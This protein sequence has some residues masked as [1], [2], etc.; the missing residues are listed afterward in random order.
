MDVKEVTIIIVFAV[1]LLIGVIGFSNPG[2]GRDR[3]PGRAIGLW[4]FS[5]AGWATSVLWQNWFGP[6][7]GSRFLSGVSL[8]SGPLWISW[9]L[10][11]KFDIRLL[12]KLLA[13]LVLLY[14]SVFILLDRSPFPITAFAL[15]AGYTSIIITIARIA[16]RNH[17]KPARASRRLLFV[18]AVPFG[19]A[20]ML[21]VIAYF[22]PVLS[23]GYLYGGALVASQAA[24]IVA[25]REGWLPQEK[26]FS[27]SMVWVAY[28]VVA[29]G[30]MFIPLALVSWV[31]EVKLPLWMLLA[32]VAVA[33]TSAAIFP[34]LGPRLALLLERTFF[35]NALKMR[36]EVEE[37]RRDIEDV[38]GKLHRAERMRIVG[39]ISAQVAH[40][41]KN[42]LGPIKGY[43][44]L[45]LEDFRSGA[46]ETAGAEK[47][48]GII[49]EE[50]E[51]IDERISRLLGFARE[52]NFSRIA[53]D[54]NNACRHAVM[55]IEAGD[56]LQPECRIELDLCPSGGEILADSSSIEEAVYNLLLNAA[57]AT[58]GEGRIRVKSRWEQYNGRRWLFIEISDDGPGFSCGNPEELFKPFYTTKPGGTGLGLGIV[59]NIVKT[60]GG[61]ITA[62]QGVNGGAVFIIRLP[63]LEEKK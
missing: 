28:A 25:L 33:L 42:P 48:L 56:E 24:L 53:V 55:L 58:G 47:G 61:E 45:L 23:R 36:R 4:A 35:P 29:G 59:R 27:R 32:L 37:L 12:P 39:E 18:I 34:L 40:E 52:T 51:R 9:A 63:A 38:R 14:I 62:Q 13:A 8:A 5:V 11:Q 26:V 43:A 1:N 7:I 2:H 15:F 41:I 21:S 17:S 22:Y 30:A 6:G 3:S 60:H 16:K 50:A 20:G 10:S 57:Q 19:L 44:K 31:L 49:I 46:L 54:P